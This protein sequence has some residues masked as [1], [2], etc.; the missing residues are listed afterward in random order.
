MWWKKDNNK[1]DKC[2]Q[3]SLKTPS[4]YIYSP[5]SEQRIDKEMEASYRHT[6]HLIHL[7]K[8]SLLP[9]K[10]IED[11]NIEFDEVILKRTDV[12][13]EAQSFIANANQKLEELAFPGHFK[14]YKK[15][16]FYYQIGYIGGHYKDNYQRKCLRGR[17]SGEDDIKTLKDFYTPT[18]NYEKY[19]CSMR[20]FIEMKLQDIISFYEFLPDFY[21]ECLKSLDNKQE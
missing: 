7:E 11:I 8:K 21:Q 19:L 12:L 2:G 3:V 15:S 6:Q 9:N 1:C 5:N 18:E 13:R 20:P 10:K 17:F 16:E 14:S 4:N